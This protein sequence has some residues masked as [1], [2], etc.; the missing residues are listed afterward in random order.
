[1]AKV[2]RG[3]LEQ[4]VKE[5]TEAHLALAC[6]R[7]QE[8]QVLL[9]VNFNDIKEIQASIGNTDPDKSLVSEIKDLSG[10][11][12]LSNRS[13]QELRSKVFELE[14]TI[15][16]LPGEELA[17]QS[18]VDTLDE[19]FQELK[20]DVQNDKNRL[21]NS[22]SYGFQDL[23]REIALI[24]KSQQSRDTD[25]VQ[26][27]LTLQGLSADGEKQWDEIRSIKEI[28]KKETIGLHLVIFV[29][30]CSIVCYHLFFASRAS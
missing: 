27:Y 14:N 11:I 3:A 9:A 1:M 20:L 6:K 5:N 22:M 19:E 23:R 13:V 4:H 8:F 24:K 2:Q 25:Y 29:I 17:L 12:R 15:N 7:L 28:I 21:Q 18:E 26:N 30:V 10:S 16:D